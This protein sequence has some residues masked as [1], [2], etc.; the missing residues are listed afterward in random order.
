ML[1]GRLPRVKIGTLPTPL[2]EAPRLSAALGGPRIL[3]KRDDL[4]GLAFGGNKVR[5]LEFYIA[6]AL[7]QGADIVITS[8]GVQ[9]NHARLTAAAARKFG[10]DCLLVLGQRMEYEMQA[11]LLLD[12]LLGAETRI[13]P[14]K[15]VWDVVEHV[16]KAAEEL[17]AQGRKPYVV[18]VGGSGPLGV[19]G[20]VAGM[21]ELTH[22]CSDLGI[23]PDRL[24]LTL[25]SGST[26][27]GCVLGTRAFRLPCR[28]AGVSCSRNRADGAARVAQ[29]ANQTAP[30]LDLDV[31][32]TPDEIEAYDEYVG[33]FY[34]CMT[35][36]CR[37]AIELVARTEGIFLD[38][39]YTG[40]AMA[41]LIDHIRQGLVGPSETIIFLHTGGTPGLFA[42][43]KELV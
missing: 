3:F 20:Y 13:I 19:T 11:N 29:L 16:D 37:E 23:V 6:D 10:M 12:N 21:L 42:Y 32:V 31:G 34:G 5:K 18:P 40:K 4:T 7:Q 26:M 33:G 15:D 8:G 14:V 24:Y 35:G 36:P 30:F 38:P 9:S 22:Q 1:L 17:R 2:E 27:S 28:V 39:V 43:S 25:G 41:G